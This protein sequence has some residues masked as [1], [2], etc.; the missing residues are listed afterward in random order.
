MFWQRFHRS[1]PVPETGPAEPLLIGPHTVPLKLVRHPRARRYRL[2]L[3]DDGSARVTIPRGGSL[4]EARQFIERSRAWL[5]TQLQRLQSRPRSPRAWPPGVEI[6]FRGEPVRLEASGPGQIR[7]AGE[8]VRADDGTTDWRP[9]VEKHL[10]AVAV[11]EL[12]PRVIA[13]AARHAL[14][15]QRIT[16]RNQRSRW[17]SCSRRGSISLNWRLVQMPPAVADYIILHELAH[18]RQ[19]NHSPRF[20]QEVE[21]LCPDYRAAEAW[22]KARR[23]LLR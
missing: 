20:W 17:G 1:A 16:I 23:Q 18:L 5:E 12:P 14:A 10:R 6:L 3:H 22:L 7:F 8:T 2:R 19:M 11:R 21:R 13:L 15:V 4:A 9:A